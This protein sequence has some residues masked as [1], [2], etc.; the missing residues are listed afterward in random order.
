MVEER[1]GSRIIHILRTQVSAYYRGKA[2]GR[3]S[4]REEIIQKNRM[5]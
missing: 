3:F 5:Q 1:V 4:R 2:V